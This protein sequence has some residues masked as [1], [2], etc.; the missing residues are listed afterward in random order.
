MPE[1]GSCDITNGNWILS[2]ME[3]PSDPAGRQT[4]YAIRSVET[5]LALAPDERHLSVSRDAL[6]LILGAANSAG[7]R[8]RIANS[9][10]RGSVAGDLL[11]TLYTLNS[12]PDYFDKPSMNQAIHVASAFGRA[13]RKDPVF[14]PT[15]ASEIRECFHEFRTVAH[16][17]AAFRLNMSLPIRSN[18]DWLATPE[19]FNDFLGVAAAL[20]DFGCRFCPPARV[21]ANRRPLL[22]HNDLWRIP[23]HIPRLQPPWKKPP[24]WYIE[25]L[26]GFKKRRQ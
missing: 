9:V 4:A 21:K 7:M 14:T 20:Q 8:G 13:V 1:I 2:I 18:G 15:S 23:A 24:A 12:F 19:A 11:V 22:G 10:M 5:A 17:W 6:G 25:T 16:L 26:K 3:F